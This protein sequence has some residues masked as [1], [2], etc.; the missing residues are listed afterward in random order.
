[1]IHK[2]IT[3][4][5]HYPFLGENNRSANVSLYLPDPMHEMGRGDWKKP[6]LVICPGGGYGMCSDR[7]A[8]PVALH[9]LS[10]GYN[11]F[12][13][14]Y[15]VAPHRFPSQ[16]HE[17]AAV[18]E[19]ICQNAD[20]W[21]CDINRVAILGF[22]AGGHLA[23]HYSTCFDIPEVRQLFPESKPVQ[24]SVLCYPVISA[25]PCI[26][27]L[28][29]FQN[30]LGVEALT[31]NQINEFSC[32][33][34]VT[35]HTPPAFMWHTAEDNLVPVANSLRYATALTEHKIPVS[36]H[37]Y[38]AGW[39]G[40]STVDDQTNDPLPENICYAADWLDAAKKWLKITLG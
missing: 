37:V 6:C 39:H 21:H 23:A 38:P 2:V 18:M 36:I 3:L 12:V 19:L 20:V 28:G 30:L 1:M 31:D 29:S 27:H 17:V 14:R 9:F 34:R 40:L 22:S 10:Q 32:D 8:E 24:A 33:R 15:S 11:V 5:D 7:E 25:D 26:A 13:L 35:D 16:L 4:K